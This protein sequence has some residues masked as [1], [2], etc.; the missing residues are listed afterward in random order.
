MYDYGVSG[1]DAR[2]QV[3]RLF[4][5]LHPLYILPFL[6]SSRSVKEEFANVFF[7]LVLLSLS[8]VVV[9]VDVTN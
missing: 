8:L 5:H 4:H 9:V 6:A 7:S 3:K 1:R 2:T